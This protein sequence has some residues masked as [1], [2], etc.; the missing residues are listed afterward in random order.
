MAL[1]NSGDPPYVTTLTGTLSP[2]GQTIVSAHFKRS[3]LIDRTYKDA[4]NNTFRQYED[5]LME[6]DI[7][8]LPVVVP[9][10]GFSSATDSFLYQ[11]KGAAAAATLTNLNCRKL[12]YNGSA[13]GFSPSKVTTITCTVSFPADDRYFNEITF[14]K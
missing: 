5:D 3:R 6:W 1:V 7:V 14:Y 13:S 4:A 11:K 12:F 2:D 9:N 10:R 8:N